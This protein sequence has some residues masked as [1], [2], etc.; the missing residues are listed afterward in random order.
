MVDAQIE[1]LSILKHNL[2]RK[3]DT[4]RKLL[5]VLEQRAGVR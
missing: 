1:Q 5:S 3:A 4:L 2:E